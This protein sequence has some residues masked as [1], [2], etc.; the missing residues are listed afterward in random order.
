MKETST[1]KAKPPKAPGAFK[2]PLPKKT[3]EKKFY[4]FIGNPGDRKFF[5]SCFVLRD[6]RCVLREGLEK[7]DIKK[8]KA[9]LKV[10]KANR[11]GSVKL[12][13]LAFAGAV[14]AALAV[15]FI[16]FMNPLLERAIERGMETLFEARVDVDRFNLN[17]LRF[18]VGLDGI[19]V[20]NRDS[21]MKNL[22]QTG[23]MEF[24]LKPEAI[25]RGKIYIEEIRTDSIRFGTDRKVSGALPN[26]PPKEKKETS[27]KA[28]APPMVDLQNF[29][30]LGL[31]DREYDKLN[32][33]R[34]YDAAINAYSE[35]LEKWKGQVEQVKTRG[36]ELRASAQPLLRLNVNEMRDVQ[37][38][39]K[40]IQD[41]TAMV[42]SVQ[43]ATA[44]AKTLVDS[45]ETDV[46]AAANLERL[47]RTSITDD[48]NH[49][50]SYIDLGSGSAF[51]ALEPSI[52]EILSGTAEQYLDYGLRALEVFEKLK[53][54]NAARPK[55]EPRP[56]KST[57]VF[58]GR[59]VPFP[60]NAY[61]QFYLG[62]LASDFTLNDW[63]W[64][65]DLRGISSDPDL[66]GAP[67]TL[68]LSL[69]ETGG[70]LSRAAAFQGSADF[71]SAAT[72]RFSADF[73]G[74][75]FP[76]SLGDQLKESGIGGFNGDAAF[77]LGFAG[78][79]DGGVRGSGDVGISR[80]RLVDPEGTLAQAVDTAV[81]QAGEVRLGIGYEHFAGQDDH[82][83]LT[84]N[85]G[86]LIMDALKQTASVYAKKAA[87]DLEKA[88]REKIAGYIDGRFVSRDELDA[89]FKTAQGDK[90][91][92]DQLKNTLDSKKNEFEQKIRAAANEAVDQAKEE[93][94]RQ[95]EQAVQDA[96]EGK[97]PTFQP[98]S[99]PSLPGG[100]R[101]PGR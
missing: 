68:A 31:L 87:D 65:L 29:D 15:F 93:A 18:Q 92:M 98:P 23:R 49:L 81:R 48:L 26:R 55:S 57:V 56:K 63:N 75:G 13:P 6:D 34:A 99:V 60:A 79:T 101:I 24:R 54:M 94:Q 80:A 2:K 1:K 84:T 52:R 74:R 67:V 27:P 20:A 43:A 4:K 58:R 61:P 62:I 73:S 78:W 25:L 12:V 64:G 82:F 53:A 45:L 14:A 22:F 89:L 97:T 7:D 44:D 16:V 96:L 90:A 95:A 38:I 11:K 17:L 46:T 39:T 19:T 91:A 5:T 21:P 83:T 70:G 32:T 33:P 35:S 100:V 71:R 88:L 72:E 40:A 77:T 85:I 3:L 37:T 42:N 10:I 28:E 47:A 51:S 9:L 69:S 30:A 50:K 41:I 59:D 66:S 36:D 86:S 8:L 76:V